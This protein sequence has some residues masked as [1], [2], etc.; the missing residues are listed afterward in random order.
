LVVDVDGLGA[1][2]RVW[3]PK[4]GNREARALT[5][6]KWEYLAAARVLGF[7][8]QAPVARKKFGFKP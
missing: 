1:W 5:L 7:P 8:E 3:G 6:L 4:K 2:I